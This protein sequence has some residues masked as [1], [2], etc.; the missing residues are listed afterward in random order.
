MNGST[1]QPLDSHRQAVIWQALVA[2][3]AIAVYAHTLGHGFVYDSR[4]EVAANAYIRSLA[5]LPEIFTTT[6]WAGSE[7]ESYLYRPLPILSYAL[8]YQLSGLAAWSYH[9]VNMLLHGLVAVLVFRI[10]LSW[11]LAPAAA[12]LGALFFAVHPV[13]VEA[14]AA[15]F[16]RKDLLAAVF[17]LAM[18]LWHRRA[19]ERGGWCI[20]LPVAAYACALLSKEVGAVAIVLVLA[21]D[22]MLRTP[23]ERRSVFR[24]QRIVGLYAVYLLVLAAYLLVR[25]GV[26]GSLGVPETSYLDNPLVVT[27]VL[28]RVA[29]AIVT[30]GLGVLHLALPLGLSPDYSYDAIP[31]VQSFFDWRLLSTLGM[32]GLAAFALSRTRGRAVLLPIAVV[33]YAVTLLPTSNLLVTVGTI[34]GDRLLYLPS[35]A[36]CLVAGLAFVRLAGAGRSARVGAVMAGSAVVLLLSLQAVRYASVW[37]DDLTL[38][39]WATRVEPASTRAHHKVGE[40]LP[41]AGQL[42]DA[43]RSLRR[44]LAIAPDNRYAAETLG[45][46]E[47]RIVEWYLA[48]GSGTAS[49]PQDPEI[50]H[51]L[52]TATRARGDLDE[53][54]VWWNRALAADPTHA[55]SHADLGVYYVARGDTTAGVRYIEHAVILTPSLAGAWLNLARIRLSR[56]DTSGAVFALRR[57]LEHASPTYADRIAWAR[58]VLD[59]IER[60]GRVE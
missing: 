51:V 49:P 23:A 26:V 53:A 34:F 8:N 18:V 9:L 39:R 32:L 5:Y 2:V 42:G 47:R 58:R 43:V 35:V 27:P 22:W 52:G 16:G 59:E 4:V 6:S 19:T 3:A 24:D 29:T 40:E 50:L 48:G 57:F 46:A 12:G 15:V 54:A 20:I 30:V 10:G 21:Q 55:R 7:G 36:F 31:V 44:A 28:A 56:S 25:I 41:R 11:R 45:Q 38:F 33:W 13:H 60:R 14:V 37:T 1:V 17:A